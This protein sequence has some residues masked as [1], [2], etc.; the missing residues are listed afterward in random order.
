MGLELR[1]LFLQDKRPQPVF[2]KCVLVRVCAQVCAGVHLRV[3]YFTERV[4]R[5]D[6]AP[7]LTELGP[8]IVTCA[9][10]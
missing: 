9:P 10:W 7:A 2:P 4:L 6:S 3:F 1:L 5:C 8:T